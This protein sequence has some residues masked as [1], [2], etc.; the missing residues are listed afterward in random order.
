M[1][2]AIR[3]QQFEKVYSLEQKVWFKKTQVW[4]KS[5]QI[6]FYKF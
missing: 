4:I 3:I 2:D 1:L 6:D 5:L